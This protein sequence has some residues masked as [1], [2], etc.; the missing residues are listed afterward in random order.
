MA[1]AVQQSKFRAPGRVSLA[2]LAGLA[3]LIGLSGCRPE[4]AHAPEVIRPVRTQLVSPETL[5]V[6]GVF[7]GDVRP[8]VES[9]LGF[10]ISGRLAERQVQLGDTVTAG[11]SLARVDPQ[12]L[13]LAE[14]G[15]RA[16]LAAAQVE[17]GRT[18][19][20]LQRYARLRETGLHQPGRVRS[21]PGRARR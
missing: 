16:E 11:Q 5:D 13:E 17:A 2:L 19:A 12:D 4:A 21:A 7:P 10:Q 18:D 14:A 1:V 15:A 6:V 20:D 3:L 9:R 8:R